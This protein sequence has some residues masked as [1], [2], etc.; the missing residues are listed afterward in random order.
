MLLKK[1]Y[2]KIQAQMYMNPNQIPSNIR[3]N[4]SRKIRILL[5]RYYP[6]ANG[7]PYSPKQAWKEYEKWLG[8]DLLVKAVMRSSTATNA[9]M[10]YATDD[11]MPQIIMEEFHG[12]VNRRPPERDNSDN[13]GNDS[14]DGADDQ[15]KPGKDNKKRSRKTKSPPQLNKKPRKKAKSSKEDENPTEE[16]RKSGN[17]RKAAAKKKDDSSSDSE[18]GKYHKN[19]CDQFFQTLY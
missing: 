18:T 16:P 2:G 12:R 3:E 7:I 1:N 8:Y 19:S 14:S 4:H 10:T 13:S 5:D 11:L 9:P 15:P 6:I 17:R